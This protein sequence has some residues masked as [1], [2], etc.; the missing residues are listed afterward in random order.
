MTVAN[1]PRTIAAATTRRPDDIKAS[2][3]VLGVLAGFDADGAPLVQAGT[4]DALAALTVVDLGHEHIGARVALQ[5][6]GGDP[7]AP[8][9]MGIVRAPRADGGRNGGVAPLPLQA[10]ADGE[11]LVLVAHRR[12]T[13]MCGAASITLDADGNVEIRGK[14]LLSRAAGQNR[15]KG[16]SV[17]LN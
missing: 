14:H 16:G 9:I 13:L 11:E 7:A 5:F 8:V 15:I 12:I 17:S 10:V 3:M 1:P 6:D 4:R 2:G